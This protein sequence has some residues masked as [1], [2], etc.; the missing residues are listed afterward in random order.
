MRPLAL[1]ELEH[2]TEEYDAAVF[3]TP[4]IDR[5]C[6]GSDWVLAAREVWA[7]GWPVE[8]LQGEDGYALFLHLMGPNAESI[9]MG[10][11]AT[12]GFACP[13]A[14]PDPEALA[15]GFS[16]ACRSRGARWRVIVIPGLVPGARLERAIEEEF[17]PDHTLEQ[18]GRVRRWVAGLGDGLDAY[19]ARRP[20]KLRENLRR[21]RRRAAEEGVRFET[22][23]SGEVEALLRR[24]LVIESRSWKG[25]EST[26]LFSHEMFRFYRL[27]ARRLAARGGLRLLFARRG[28]EDLGYI[29]GGVRRGLYR[30]LQ[31]SFD[32]RYAHLSLGNL[33]Q[34]AQIAALCEEGVKTYDLGM[35]MAYK[36]RWADRSFETEG[37]VAVRRSY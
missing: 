6:T 7:V 31:F 16:E 21:A 28:E 19:L 25:S 17:A 37:L 22:G 8:I 26:G 29:L 18:G 32:R 1:E 10:F 2:R 20:R 34:L 5:F 11:D 4:G 3:A 36:R 9:L 13:L 33:M 15:A 12:W 35:D 27:L 14:G 23:E 30:G 24:V